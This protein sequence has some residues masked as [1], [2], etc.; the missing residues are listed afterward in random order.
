MIGKQRLKEKLLMRDLDEVLISRFHRALPEAG[1]YR[2]FDSEHILT[3]LLGIFQI[4]RACHFSKRGMR[5]TNPKWLSQLYTEL[6]WFPSGDIRVGD[7]LH[8]LCRV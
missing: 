4:S 8:I 7:V 6:E 1:A 2:A 5:Y 3:R